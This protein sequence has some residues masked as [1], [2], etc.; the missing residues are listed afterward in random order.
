MAETTDAD[1]LARLQ[2]AQERIEALKAA[3]A[4][5]NSPEARRA[6]NT[7]ITQIRHAPPPI[8]AAFNAWKAEQGY[9]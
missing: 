5:M 7:L 4:D 3:H 6:V 9:T 8:L 1:I 2:Q